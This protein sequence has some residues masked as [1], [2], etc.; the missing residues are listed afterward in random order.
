MGLHSHEEDARREL[1]SR[2][3]SSIIDRKR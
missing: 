1:D 2:P 3:A